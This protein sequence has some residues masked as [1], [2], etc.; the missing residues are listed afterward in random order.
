VFLPIETA[1]ALVIKEDPT[2]FDFA[3]DKNIVLITNSTLLATLRTISYIWR[4]ENQKKNVLEIARQSGALYD[5]FADFMND[6][7]EVGKKIDGAKES[8]HN[9]MNKLFDSKKKGDTLIGRVEK[10]KEL[11]A[12]TTKMLPKEILDK[13]ELEQG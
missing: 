6:L 12:K 1:F 8:H 2:I 10:I 5:K 7:I 3:F 13:L 11:G 4:Q 9:A